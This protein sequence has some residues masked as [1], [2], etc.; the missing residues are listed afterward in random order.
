MQTAA[1]IVDAIR[2][3]S[4]EDATKL[5][6]AF[7]GLEAVKAEREALLNALT[8]QGETIFLRGYWWDRRDTVDALTSLLIDARSQIER[9]KE[10]YD[11]AMAMSEKHRR[12]WVE[13]C[14][15]IKAT[16]ATA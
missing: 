5:I 2:G 7:V 8:D 14:Q 1:D 16:L 6:E 10:H 9:D 4:R 3:L 11:A 13:E 15:K 12:L